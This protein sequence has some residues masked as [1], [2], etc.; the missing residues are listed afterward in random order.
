MQNRAFRRLAKEMRSTHRKLKSWSKTAEAHNITDKTGKPSKAIAWRIV[1]DGFQPSDHQTLLRIG[2][3][4]D[5]DQCKKEKQRA[6]R[7]AH[8]DL[9]DMNDKAILEAL[10]NRTPFEPT[11]NTKMM[12]EF[13]KACKRKGTLQ[14]VKATS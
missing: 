9:F 13:I 10:K 12:A 4:C 1:F 2:M 6:K 14:R 3:P 7:K 8:L 5:C 11:Y